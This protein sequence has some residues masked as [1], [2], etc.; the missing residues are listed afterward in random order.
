VRGVVSLFLL[1][2]IVHHFKYGSS[3]AQY[4]CGLLE[5]NM[6]IIRSSGDRNGGASRAPA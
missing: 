6:Q 4:N 5:E 2:R 3:I 1:I